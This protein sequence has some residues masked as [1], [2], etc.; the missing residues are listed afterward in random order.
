MLS[1]QQIKFVLSNMHYDGR[2]YCYQTNEPEIWH[3]L[4][5][6]A[7]YVVDFNH[8]IRSFSCSGLS[9]LGRDLLEK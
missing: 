8:Q 3:N 1:E 4:N 5:D 7:P 9:Q 6:I 2:Y